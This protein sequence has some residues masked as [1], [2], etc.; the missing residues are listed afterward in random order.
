MV[1]VRRTKSVKGFTLVELLVVIA[2]IGILVALLLPAVQAAR[3]AARRMQCQNN[4]KQIGLAF[5]NYHSTYNVFPSGYIA[6]IP[7]SQTSSEVGMWAWGTFILPFIEQSG[8]YD[9]LSPNILRLEQSAATPT[10]LAALQTP[11]PGFRCP[12]DIGPKLNN[13]DNTASGHEIVG[14]QYSRFI[15]NGSTKIA[16]ATSNY[17]ACMGPGD[18]TTPAVDPTIYGRPLGSCT[19]IPMSACAILRMGRLTLSVWV[20]EPG[21]SQPACRRRSCYGISA[22]PLANIDQGS[23]WNVKSAGTNVMSLTYDGPNYSPGLPG[24][25]GQRRI[26]RE[27]STV[28]T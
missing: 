23:S 10:G 11:L 15:T 1:S 12:S 27:R 16:I 25:G 28:R 9:A 2:I 24:S 4:L 18:S 19:R 26:K 21:S 14:N 20:K 7:K 5:Q 13:F 17:V 8:L 3:E 6:R 22:S